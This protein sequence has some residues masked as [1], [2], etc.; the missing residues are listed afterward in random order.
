MEHMGF[1]SVSMEKCARELKFVEKLGASATLVIGPLIMDAIK[2]AVDWA[3]VAKKY[4]NSKLK[5]AS[6]PNLDWESAK[7]EMCYMRPRVLQGLLWEILY[8]L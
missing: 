3:K 4:R 5:T 7:G 6:Y 2:T 1:C 8:L